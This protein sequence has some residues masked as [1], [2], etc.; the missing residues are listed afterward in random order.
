MHWFR[1]S[2][3]RSA[4]KR[5]SQGEVLMDVFQEAARAAQGRYG[6]AWFVLSP[7][8]QTRAIYEEMR[9]I[10]SELVDAVKPSGRG[11]PAGGA[12][13]WRPRCSAPGG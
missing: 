5:G 3:A 4:V 10:D 13:R 12:V 6:E 11:Q 8:E 7:Q 1:G 9:R 2:D